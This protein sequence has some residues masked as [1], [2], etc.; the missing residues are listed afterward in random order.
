MGLILNTPAT[1]DMIARCNSLFSSTYL[2]FWRQSPRRGWFCGITTKKTLHDIATAINLYPTAGPGSPEGIRW[3]KWLQEMDKG[4][5][6]TP[7]DRIS[8]CICEALSDT[9]CDEIVFNVVPTSSQYPTASCSQVGPANGYSKLI[10][11]E[12]P[13]LDT[14]LRQV[15]RR[16][17]ARTKSKRKKI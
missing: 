5:A 4:S 6:P 11:V 17:R 1:L 2:P 13:T 16:K 8:D 14:M 3:L 15:R 9:N 10:T 7:A 12:T